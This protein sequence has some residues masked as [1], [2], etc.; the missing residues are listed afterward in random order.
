MLDNNPRSEYK[1]KFLKMAAVCAVVGLGVGAT[2]ATAG[3]LIT[4][5]KIK[6]G[7]IQTVDL[8]ASAKRA[9]KGNTGS[10]GRPGDIGL[11]GPA[12]GFDP[13]RV[14]YVEGPKVTI[15][16]GTVGNSVAQCPGGSKVLGGGHFFGSATGNINV[17]M[18]TPV[19][20][21][22]WFAGFANTGSIEGHATAYA[23]CAN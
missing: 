22:G 21:T 17:E 10:I 19:G 20:G 11:Q 13:A 8:S 16:P 1:M 6:N 9:L 12:G 4:S 14:T 7:T 3:S 2:T 23:V 18:S 15:A 5:A